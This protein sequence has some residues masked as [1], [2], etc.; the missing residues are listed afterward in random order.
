MSK[1]KQ[2]G[3]W[4]TWMILFAVSLPLVYIAD[5]PRNHSIWSVAMVAAV[6]LITALFS[7][8]VQ[9]TDIIVLQGIGLAAFLIFGLFI[10]V[11]L[12]QFGI[13][14]YLINQR[15]SKQ[16]TY[17]IPMNSIMFLGVSVSAAAV[18]YALGGQAEI[19]HQDFLPLSLIPVVGFYLAAYIVNEVFIYFYHRWLIAD[20]TARLFTKD[21]AWEIVVTFLMMPLGLAFYFMYLSRGITGMFMISVPMIALSVIMRLVNNSQELIRFLQQVNH[22]GQKLTEELSV[23]H[24]INLLFE[25]IPVM[26]PLDYL[27][28]ISYRQPDKPKLLRIFRR[29]DEKN[30]V[31]FQQEADP[32]QEVY[33]LAKAVSGYKSHEIYPFLKALSSGKARSFLAVPMMYHGQVLGVLTVAS[34]RPK[35]YTKTNRIGMEIIGDFLAIALENAKNFEKKR[36]ESE[37]C[38]LT[39]LYNYRYMMR[40][41]D[42]MFKDESLDTFSIIMMDIDDFKQV[43]DTY[44]HQNGNAI[45][46]GVANRLRKTV[47][48]KGIVARYGGEEFTVLLPKMDRNM[49][50]AI[51]ESIRIAVVSEPF[52]V[53][54][55]K[56][57]RYK[58]VHITISLGTSTARSEASAPA[59]LINN[60]DFAMYSGAKR[61]GKNR[62]SRFV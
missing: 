34:N 44:G 57:Q 55:E 58:Q 5:P 16:D 29:D 10:E 17:R 4:L 13:L 37:H 26:T 6:F 15:L 30:F 60:A 53:Y 47:G 8:K 11:L 1:A 19:S 23:E 62:V 24:V 50:F 14:V 7:F 31:P 41:L 54:L 52:M 25:K 21:M 56:E 2:R 12:T 40:Q 3:L 61:K 39:D 33:R 48:D 42:Q 45:L 43:N 36:E 22:L 49:C 59:A 27:Y 20:E 18:Y 38:P 46:I 28:I 51:A 32:S 9:G 35:A